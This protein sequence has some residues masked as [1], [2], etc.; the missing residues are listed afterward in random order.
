VRPCAPEGDRRRDHRIK[1]PAIIITITTIICTTIT[2]IIT[3]TR[4][5]K[6]RCET[7]MHPP[8]DPTSAITMLPLA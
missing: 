1:V 5:R 8:V 3:R 7:S 4:R 6:R 2:T